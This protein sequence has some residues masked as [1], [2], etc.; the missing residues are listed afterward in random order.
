MKRTHH[1]DIERFDAWSTTYDR[2]VGQYF[3]GQI[4]RPVLAAAAS[5]RVLPRRVADLGCGTGRLL[6]ALLARLPETELVGVDPAEGMIAVARTRF[7]GEP[8][9]RL[10][11]AT[12]EQLPL[13]DASVDV[14]TTTMSFHHWEHQERS[15]QEVVRV[16]APGGRLLLADVLGIGCFGRLMRS[17]ARGHGSGYRSAEELATLLRAAGFARWRRRQL[18]PGVP[19]YLVEARRAPDA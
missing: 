13:A 6:E 3:F 9:V 12:A 18:W 4:H 1:G 14:A 11:V 10:E 15:L 17:L 2:G 8:R 7:A 16:L 5:G 19:I